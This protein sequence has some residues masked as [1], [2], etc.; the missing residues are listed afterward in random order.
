MM[1]STRRLLGL[2]AAVALA[3]CSFRTVSD[4]EPAGGGGASSGASGGN[5]GLG[6]SGWVGGGTGNV[7]GGA[8]GSGGTV[9]SCSGCGVQNC[10]CAPVAPAGWLPGT[11]VIGANASCPEGY[12]LDF[13]GGKAPVDTGCGPCQCDPPSSA[14]CF[15]H[16]FLD[17][18]CTSQNNGFSFIVGKCT[19]F[20]NTPPKSFSVRGSGCGKAKSTP[21]APKFGTEVTVC[22]ASV[23]ADTC[24]GSDKCVPVSKYPFET[25]PCIVAAQ[26][27]SQS[28]PS[29]YPRRHVYY[30]GIDDKRSCSGCTCEQSGCTGGAIRWC[31][32]SNCSSC[33]SAIPV[34]SCFANP[35]T[36]YIVDKAPSPP[37]CQVAGNATTSGSLG[38]KTPRTI[39]CAD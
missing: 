6:T 15:A 32:G 25:A 5:A 10:G 12:A 20:P 31:G 37:S 9:T 13:V 27:G 2:V 23:V 7:Q 33:S 39:C 16:L 14:F 3:A 26:A 21:L 1:P 36:S 29:G 11:L 19:G 38:E 34:E 8:A 24:A 28:C 30:E 35:V 4:P 22:R 17:Q 18:K